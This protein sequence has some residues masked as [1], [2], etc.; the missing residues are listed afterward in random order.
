MGSAAL[1]SSDRPLRLVLRF[2]LRLLLGSLAHPLFLTLIS[3]QRLAELV[4]SLLRFLPGLLCLSSL[5]FRLQSNLLLVLL[6]LILRS[7][8]RL[9][10]LVLHLLTSLLSLLCLSVLL[11]LSSLLGDLLVLL[12]LLFPFHIGQVMVPPL[13][14]LTPLIKLT[15]VCSKIVLR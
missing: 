4:L 11:C 5:L 10:K 6:S 7:G 14:V 13:S 9:G 1:S 15:G 8:Q 12:I 2:V 3:S